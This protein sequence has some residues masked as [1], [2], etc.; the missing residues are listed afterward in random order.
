MAKTGLANKIFINLEFNFETY[1]LKETSKEAQKHN[2]G[3]Q[4]TFSLLKEVKAA[5]EIYLALGVEQ[6]LLNQELAR[7]ANSPEEA[8]SI[9]KAIEQLQDARKSLTV[10]NDSQAYQK[11]T[12]TYPSK[13]KEAGLPID[14]FRAFLKSHS[15][16]LTN[17]MASPLSVTEKNI[18]RQRKENLAM[19]KEVYI[20]MQREA[21]GLPKAP[22]KSRGLSL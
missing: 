12:E 13:N 1:Q 8:N 19:I 17:R 15:T 9:K 11:A 16:R 6:L 18:L 7:Y 22:E 2:E 3:L 14:S 20:E 10:V 21:L 5:K 4:D